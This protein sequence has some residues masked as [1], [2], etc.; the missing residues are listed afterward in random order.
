M[1]TG[2]LKM[3]G[4]QARRTEKSEALDTVRSIL[5]GISSDIVVFPEKWVTGEFTEEELIG[6]LD[7]VDKD[8]IP[9]F[10]PGSFS[11]RVGTSLYN[12]SYLFH[13]GKMVGHQYKISLYADE[14]RKYRSGSSIRIFT[15]GGLSIGLPICYDIDFPYYVKVLMGSGCNIV[16]NP[17]L[18]RSDF[19]EEW[20][21][22]ISA[23]SLENR[24]PII[25]VNSMSDPFGGN[26]IAVVPYRD[27]SGFR[28]RKTI[29]RDLVFDALLNPEDY[30]EGR[31]KRYG[32]DPGTYSF[33]RVENV[34][35]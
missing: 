17:S 12:R 5:S 14:P 8:H 28:I 34:K 20:H 10:I 29:S 11:I 21:L 2:T 31:Q 30:E 32:E 13:Y 15:G 35:F 4:V 16:I 26:S 33:P 9:F 25:S 3:T 23:R 27:G 22:Y 1:E 24:V 6:A 18:I 19:V 7:G